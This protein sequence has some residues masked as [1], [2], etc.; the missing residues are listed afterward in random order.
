MKGHQKYFHLVDSKGKLMPHFITISNIESRDPDVVR[1]GNERVIRPRLSD[2]EFFWSQDRKHKLEDQIERLKTVVFQKKLGTLFDKTER[3]VQLSGIIADELNAD[4]KL[5]ERAAKLCKCDLMSEMVYEFPELQGIMGRYYAVHDGEPADVASAIDEHYM[6]RFAGDDLPAT[7]TGQ[8][9]SIADKLDTMVG[10]FGI[11]QTPSG[12]KD[13]FGLRRAS[14]GILR[15]IIE[16]GLVLELPKLLHNAVEIYNQQNSKSI[17]PADTAEQV[18]EF[19][20]GR[21]Q[22]YYGN[23]GFEHDEIDAV[24]CLKPADLSDLDKKIRALSAFRKMPEAE[25]LAAANKRISNILKKSKDEIPDRFD[26]AALQDKE[27]QQLAD[28]VSTLQSSLEPVFAEQNYEDAMK[29]LA[30]LR[31]SV[32]QF[33]DSVM[34]MVEDKQLRA[35]RLALLSAMRNLFIKVADLSKLQ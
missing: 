16:G 26:N 22:V 11:G 14:L 34:V 23:Q 28:Q 19:I 31:E 29:Q 6:P 13:P 2:A 18:F 7:Q 25:S 8:I 3:V 17:I 24:I 15:I 33:F 9:V 20:L 10:I 30:G 32:D 21:L 4:R 12:D 35:N 27:E 1:E 5:A